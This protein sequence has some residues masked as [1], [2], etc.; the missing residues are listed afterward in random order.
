MT[1]AENPRTWLRP[2]GN[3]GLIASAVIAGAAPLGSMPEAFGYDVS[4]DAAVELVEAILSSPI[5][6][7]D[8][9][10]GYSDG[11]S[12]ARIGMAIARA[13]GLP[14]D[15]LG[16]TKVD[17]LGSDYSG[18]RVR[19]SIRESKARLGLET[20]PLVYLHDPEFHPFSEL[21]SSR[22]AVET[23]VELKK[24]GEIG[25]IG[26]AGGDVHELAKYVDL[27]V[28]EVLLT[29]NRWTLVD[30]SAGELI[31]RARAMGLAV[32]NAAI[33][34][35]GI[36]A[37]PRGG[38]TRYGYRQ[39]SKA[40]LAAISAM[41]DLAE[42]YDTDLPTLALQA[43]L[44]DPQVDS[45]VIGFSRTGRIDGIMRAAARELPSELWQSLES[46]LPGRENWLDFAD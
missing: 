42:H 14:A 8:T 38:A 11:R 28:F 31:D 44:R 7:I 35:G 37:N 21:A 36:L 30:R 20:L 13:G 33:Y 43:S 45:T 1:A 16:A 32:V 17:A 24:E 40:T 19:A 4:E 15:F 29:H 3:T 23:L 34:G 27:G 10:N 25:H 18:D 41:A 39:A 12:E 9:S 6:T 2:L 22:G 26:V 5:R 46:L